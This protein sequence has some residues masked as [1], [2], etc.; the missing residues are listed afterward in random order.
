M[1]VHKAVVDLHPKHTQGMPVYLLSC[2]TG[3]G[4]NSYAEQLS[5]ELKIPV[6][7]PDELL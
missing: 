7:A 1:P 4:E 5:K 2:N 6:K 3:K